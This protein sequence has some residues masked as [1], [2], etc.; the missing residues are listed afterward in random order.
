MNR[1]TL[2][3][4]ALTMMAVGMLLMFAPAAFAADAILEAIDA[5][6]APVLSIYGGK[7]TTYRFLQAGAG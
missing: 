7:I 4:L 3:K 1:K 6:G 5:A 2:S